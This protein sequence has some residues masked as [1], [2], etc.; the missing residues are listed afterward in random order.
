MKQLTEVV[1]Y[2]MRDIIYFRN[3]V[4][5]DMNTKKQIEQIHVIE[6]MSCIKPSEQPLKV[7]KL[8]EKIHK[9][10]KLMKF[11]IQEI[12]MDRYEE[13]IQHMCTY[14]LTDEPI[15]RCMS[16]FRIFNCSLT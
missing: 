4:S 3:K 9:N 15:C 12:P 14:F 13:A 5:L 16:K 8:I 7:W 6:K 2:L 1:A 10:G 11:T